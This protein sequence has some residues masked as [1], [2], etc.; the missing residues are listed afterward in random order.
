MAGNKSDVLKNLEQ[1]PLLPLRRNLLKPGS[2]RFICHLRALY[3][4]QLFVRSAISPA[5][6]RAASSSNCSF[7]SY[8]SANASD[9]RLVAP[10]SAEPHFK[11]G[12]GNFVATSRFGED[13]SAA[14]VV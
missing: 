14:K 4:S 10:V 13:T 7:D 5:V 1:E 2:Y 9:K 3:R 8:S 12:N 6:T 11:E